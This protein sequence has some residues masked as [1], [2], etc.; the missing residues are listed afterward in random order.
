VVPAGT[1]S[2]AGAGATCST[3]TA[4]RIARRGR[5]ATWSAT[6]APGRTCSTCR[7]LTRMRP[8]P[9]TSVPVRRR[10]GSGRGAGAAGRGRVG[11]GHGRA[12]QRGRGRV[13]RARDPARR[14]RGDRPGRFLSLSGNG[15]G[16]VGGTS[17]PRRLSPSSSSSRR[18]RPLS[19]ISAAWIADSGAGGSA[20]AAGERIVSWRPSLARRRPRRCTGADPASAARQRARLWLAR[21]RRATARG[22]RRRV[23]PGRARPRVRSA[24][25]R[26]A[27]ALPQA[28][29]LHRP[30]RTAET[31][32]PVLEASSS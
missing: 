17:Y 23:R 3:M 10:D 5:G 32:A 27:S 12:R 28:V 22:R 2:R 4:W 25:D 18:D 6:S 1:C 31:P 14:T 26:P 29:S 20:V 13:G 7:A 19:R 9:A 21:A 16:A 11:R 24:P 30:P 15:C 8:P